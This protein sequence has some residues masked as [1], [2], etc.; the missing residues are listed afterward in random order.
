MRILHSSKSKQL[1]RRNI[2]LPGI[3]NI[4][5][6]SGDDDDTDNDDDD[7]D[8]DDDDDGDEEEEEED[9]VDN[10]AIV[11]VVAAADD[12]D[13]VPLACICRYATKCC[14]RSAFTSTSSGMLRS[15]V[16]DSTVSIVLVL[17]DD[18]DIAVY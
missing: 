16:L 2:S 10:S 3:G 9:R 6:I 14:P 15:Q 5:P 12:D 1:E 18:I 4:R 7:G 13:G 8:D 17:F 11:V